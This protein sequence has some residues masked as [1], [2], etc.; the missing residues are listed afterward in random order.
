MVQVSVCDAMDEN[1]FHP[2]DKIIIA[3]HDDMYYALG[4]YCGFDYTNL[5]QGALIGEK[6]MCPTCGSG[7]D[8]TTGFVESG[9]NMR[10]LSTFPIQIRKEI[11]ELTVPEH[12]P[13]FSRKR[14]LKR[15]A[16]DP[17]TFIILGDNETALAA[18]D[19]LRTG[20]TGRI[21]MIPC[22]DFGA[23]ENTDLMKRDLGPLTKNECYLVETDY[24]DRA[25]VDVI[26]G[27]VKMI[28]TINRKLQ[29][30]GYKN[31][32]NFEKVLV[33]WGANRKRLKKSYSNV[34]Y[35][36]DR[37]SHAKVHNDLLKAKQVVVLGGTLHALQV[38]QSARTYL[39]NVGKYE[40]KIMVLNDGNSEITKTLGTGM[41]RW[42][43]NA[44][45]RQRISFQPNC[46][47]V[48]LV[49]DN[50]LEKIVFHKQE[51][52]KNGQI[53]NVDYFVEPDMVIVENGIDRP[54]KE[55]MQM[56]GF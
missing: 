22:S 26:K 39:D 11:I 21:I 51:D 15:E 25:N 50:E 31:P 33:A 49:G 23:F 1:L 44:L 7:Y 19:A 52:I 8:V 55:L 30:Q 43:R 41:E 36:E 34:H 32:F 12:V 24:L 45:S 20:F 37:F 10:N 16:I 28:D 56:V 3:K 48:D 47:I 17:R 13:A 4:S 18:I 38:A 40:T 54:R 46:N 53:S 6:L 5:S 27:Q 29:V 42:F 35:I 9:P 2:T 14:F